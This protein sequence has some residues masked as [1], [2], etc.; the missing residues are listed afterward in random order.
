MR[1]VFLSRRLAEAGDVWTQLAQR[2]THELL[3]E[4]T[5][6]LNDIDATPSDRC[7]DRTALINQL[8]CSPAKDTRQDPASLR[9]F[10]NVIGAIVGSAPYRIALQN[11]YYPASGRVV[12]QGIVTRSFRVWWDEVARKAFRACHACMSIVSWA[13]PA[14]YLH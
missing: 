13:R 6:I 5:R 11:S 4:G 8:H 3:F 2:I 7:R 1:I 12:E 10:R 14:Q 9:E